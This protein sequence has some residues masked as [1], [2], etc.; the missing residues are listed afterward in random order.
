VDWI[1]VDQGWGWRALVGMVINIPF[2]SRG[3]YFNIISISTSWSLK[4]LYSPTETEDATNLA[5]LR[6]TKMRKFVQSI[7]RAFRFYYTR[8]K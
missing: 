2:L 3:S 6:L 8:D 7:L 1:R 4:L 5:D